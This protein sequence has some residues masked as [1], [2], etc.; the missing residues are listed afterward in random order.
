[1]RKSLEGVPRRMETTKER[2]GK[3]EGRTIEIA[4][5]RADF[6]GRGGP[7]SGTCGTIIKDL[8][9]MSLEDG[10]GNLETSIMVRV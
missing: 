7:S 8:T 4:Q 2:I 9:F 5:Q 6:G 3:L 10:L 1:M